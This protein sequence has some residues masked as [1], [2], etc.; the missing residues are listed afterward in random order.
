MPNGRPYESPLNKLADALPNFIL[1]MQDMRMRQE[2]QEALNQY[3]WGAL[4]EQRKAR[5]AL[6]SVRREMGYYEPPEFEM[7]RKNISGEFSKLNDPNYTYLLKDK[8]IVNQ[9]KR[10][11]DMEADYFGKVGRHITLSIPVAVEEALANIEAAKP[12]PL[13]APP[14]PEEKPKPKVFETRKEYQRRL[15]EGPKPPKPKRPPIPAY[16]AGYAPPPAPEG[17]TAVEEPVRIETDEEFEALSSGTVF[18]GPD[19]IPRTKP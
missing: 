13:A 4:E 5:M 2:A 7:M 16:R 12:P 17:V 9:W 6:E 1:Q 14:P 8:E 10:V 11:K 18:I 19:G 3:R 15:L